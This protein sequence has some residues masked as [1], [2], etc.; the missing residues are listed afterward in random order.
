MA[1]A[2]VSSTSQSLDRQIEELKKYVDES[3]IIVDKASGKDLNRN[4]FQALKSPLGLRKGDTL[5]IKSLDRLSR[6]KAD[7]KNELE[8]FKSNHVN[9][10]ILDL[11][12]TMIQLPSGQEWIR[13]MVNNIIIE[14]MS[15]I[16]EQERLTIRQRQKE[17][18]DIAKK[19]GKHMGRPSLEKPVEWEKYYDMWKRGNISAKKAMEFLNLKKTS[20]YKLVSEK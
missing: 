10:Q 5:I 14:V 2:R 6:N 20:F 19:Q 15:S 11:P 9:L 18:I 1:Y 17:G 16:A 12:T 4:G 13:D 3:N 7:I 8:W